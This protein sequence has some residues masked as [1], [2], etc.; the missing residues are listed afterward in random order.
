MGIIA[1]RREKFQQLFSQLETLLT[2]NDVT[3]C[4]F[5]KDTNLLNYLACVPFNN[6]LHSLNITRVN[7]H[8]TVEEKQFVGFILK[9]RQTKKRKMNL[10][11]D[12]PPEPQYF[13]SPPIG[14]RENPRYEEEMKQYRKK[15][16]EYQRQK[17]VLERRRKELWKSPGS[18]IF[19]YVEKEERAAVCPDCMGSGR[20]PSSEDSTDTI[21]CPRCYGKGTSGYTPKVT[22]HQ[23]QVAETFRTKLDNLNNPVFSNF[24]CKKKSVFLRVNYDGQIFIK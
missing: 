2:S 11:L 9:Y 17:E 19:R 22:P 7:I 5:F 3:P 21:D 4:H 12:T 8:L 23:R 20:M 24:P 14:W 13:D 1:R 18:K 15:L 6:L 16:E 10:L